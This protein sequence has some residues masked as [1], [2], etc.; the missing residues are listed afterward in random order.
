LTVLCGF[1][2]VMGAI[3]IG[4][5]VIRL[6]TLMMSRRRGEKEWIRVMASTYRDHIVLCGVGRLGIR[7]LEQLVKGGVPVVALERDRHGRFIP[8]A[9]DLGVPVMVRDMKEDQALIEAGIEYARAI[10][11]ATNDS[12]GNL[13]V[14][15]DARRMNPKIRIIMRMFDAQ[16]AAKISDAIDV[17]VAFS[18]SSLAAPVIAA[19]AQH[20]GAGDATV[21]S[22]TIINSVPYVAVQFKVDETSPLVGQTVH[23]IETAHAVRVL[24]LTRPGDVTQSPPALAS[25]V[26]PGDTVIVHTPAAKV[27]ELTGAGA[28]STQRSPSPVG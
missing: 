21:L 25:S 19:L 24:A 1:Y 26:S 23:A 5:G 11:I 7:I 28:A 13:E 27:G 6:A 2:P 9:K 3:V 14:A 12:M 17:D 16:V 4:E 8:G 18:S 20:I 22:T 10:I 15:L